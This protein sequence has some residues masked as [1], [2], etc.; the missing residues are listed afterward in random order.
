MS[1]P[2]ELFGVGG[3]TLALSEL[4]RWFIRRGQEAQDKVEHD[5]ATKL[6]QVLKD[7]GEI[8][9]D[10]RVV[11]EK[12]STHSSE[13]AQVKERVEGISGNYGGRIGKLE[14]DIVELRTKVEERRRK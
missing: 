1:D 7:I 13:V 4:V 10:I 6:D 3:G 5:A 9:G 12:L 11:T 2:I 8:R 14:A